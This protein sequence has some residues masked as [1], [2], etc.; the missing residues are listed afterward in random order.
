[1]NQAGHEIF[2]RDGSSIAVAAIYHEG[3]GYFN[4]DA[5][6]RERGGEFTEDRLYVEHEK[7]PVFHAL[8][9]ETD[10]RVAA[11]AIA[12]YL[13]SKREVNVPRVDGPRGFAESVKRAIS[14]D[15]PLSYLIGGAWVEKACPGEA[16]NILAVSDMTGDYQPGI[17]LVTFSRDGRNFT[18]PYSLFSEDYDPV[19]E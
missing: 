6:A 18:M 9:K 11:V 7:L 1:M 15:D 13:A 19:Q 14:G 2:W 3:E 10:L 17:Q 16:V 8:A 5:L 4:V 12:E